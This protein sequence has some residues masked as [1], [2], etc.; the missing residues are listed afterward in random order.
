MI[1]L[2]F[3]LKTRSRCSSN[4]VPRAFLLPDLTIAKALGTRLV[5][6][7]MKNLKTTRGCQ[8]QVSKIEA[9]VFPLHSTGVQMMTLLPIFNYYN[10]QPYLES[11]QKR[12][13][14]RRSFVDPVGQFNILIIDLI[15]TN[16]ILADRRFL[17]G[18]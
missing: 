12:K 4:L 17:G 14:P 16:S 1:R 9:N 3:L 15:L 2:L 5:Q 18:N 8:F 6:H 10:N 11:Q 7:W 13:M